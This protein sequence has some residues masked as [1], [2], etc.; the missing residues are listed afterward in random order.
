MIYKWSHWLQLV[1]LKKFLSL[2]EI[3]VDYPSLYMYTI[4]YTY[5]SCPTNQ[6]VASCDSIIV[7]A[8]F[9]NF[10]ECINNIIMVVYVLSVSMSHLIIESFNGTKKLLS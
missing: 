8:D 5:Y 7:T 3:E 1:N 9:V 4:L 2:E 6:G 10:P